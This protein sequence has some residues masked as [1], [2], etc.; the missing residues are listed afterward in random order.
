MKKFIMLF[1]S[2]VFTFTSFANTTKIEETSDGYLKC[3]ISVGSTQTNFEETADFYD[4]LYNVIKKAQNTD[5]KVVITY[6]G[7]W[8][9]VFKNTEAIIA[10]DIITSHFLSGAKLKSQS[11]YNGMKKVF[12]VMKNDKNILVTIR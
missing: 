6:N 3:D 8:K 12:N 9:Y 7:K 2:M 10:S 5:K 1:F 11:W 4:F